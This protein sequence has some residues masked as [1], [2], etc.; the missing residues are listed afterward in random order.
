MKS[1]FCSNYTKKKREISGFSRNWNTDFS[2]ARAEFGNF[3]IGE[4]FLAK[5]ISCARGK[6]L[7]LNFL[8]QAYIV[9]FLQNIEKINC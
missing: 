1:N 5:L 3:K 9:S 6:G 7:K 2:L 8:L 4:F